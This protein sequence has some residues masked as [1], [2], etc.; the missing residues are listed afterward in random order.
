MALGS[1]SDF[2]SNPNT[3]FVKPSAAISWRKAGASDED[4][5]RAGSPKAMWPI[6][7]ERARNQPCCDVYDAVDRD[8]RSILQNGAIKH[9]RP[10]RYVDPVPDRCATHVRMGSYEDV[11]ANGSRVL[12]GTSNHGMFHDNTALTDPDRST[13][14]RCDD[15][16]R[17][18]DRAS[19]NGNIS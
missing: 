11:A 18:H 16:T 6:G 8:H 7:H 1:A 13:S 9:C 17:Q 10:G 5:M 3:L 4:T 12:S 2:A 14:L 15:R 19:P